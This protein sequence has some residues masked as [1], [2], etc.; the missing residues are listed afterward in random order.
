MRFELPVFNIS[1]YTNT[2]PPVRE[3]ERVQERLSQHRDD[4]RFQH[5]LK[6]M[7]E[8]QDLREVDDDVEEVATLYEWH[9][10]EH[11]HQP[12]TATWF[13][14]LAIAATALVGLFIIL[15]NI[16]A[17]FTIALVSGLVYFIA[18]REPEILRYRIMVDGIAFNNTLYHFKELEAFN[19]IYEPDETK[20]AIFRSSRRFAPLLHMEIGAADP[21]TIRDIL[22]E[23]LPEDQDLE[24]PLIDVYARRLGF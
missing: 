20:T 17:A 14:V 16:I 24:E 7:Q 10:A 21:V 12:K 8:T 19:I 23:F 4:E 13:I 1:S 3:R 9:A 15:A 11:N 2:M 5:E 6:E 18:Q 22:L